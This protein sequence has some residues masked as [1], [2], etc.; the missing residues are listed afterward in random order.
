[1]T[2]PQVDAPPDSSSI[3]RS[4]AAVGISAY[5]IWGLLTLYWKL[6][7]DFAPL[8]MIGFRITTSLVMLVSF[9]TWRKRLVALLRHVTSTGL[10]ARI[11]V[12]SVVLAVNWTSYVVV[13]AEDHVVEAALGYFIAPLATMT[14]G[15]RVLGERMRTA[16]IVT[17]LLGVGSV[18]VLTI[19]YGRVPVYALLIAGSWSTYGYL[20]RTVPLSPI[21][22]LTAETTVL[23]VPAIALVVWHLQYSTNV[24]RSADAVE[25]AAVLL[26]GVI[27]VVPLTMFAYAAQRIPMT[28][29]GPMQYSVPVINFLLGWLAFGEDVSGTKF[30]GFSL[31]WVALVV[32]TVDTVRRTRRTTTV[33]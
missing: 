7:G 6:L 22:S 30:V 21:D 10:W 29:I 19:G 12:A 15:V 2:S 3:D 11:T 32:L 17:A 23:V 8:E 33:A 31:V 4:G 9:L 26:L 28:V 24:F 5:L 18:V 27:T 14:I 1:V 16:Q 25:W 13:V 20:K